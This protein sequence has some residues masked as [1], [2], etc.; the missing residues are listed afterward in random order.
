MPAAVLI[1]IISIQYK[2]SPALLHTK[3]IG[4][5][6]TGKWYAYLHSTIYTT[7]FIIFV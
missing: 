1:I 5:A 6:G 3:V 7:A 2:I 4:I